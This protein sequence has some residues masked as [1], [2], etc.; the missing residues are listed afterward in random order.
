[1]FFYC[2]QTVVIAKAQIKNY[3][4][5]GSILTK[6]DSLQLLMPNIMVHNTR[7]NYLTQWSYLLDIVQ[8]T[9]Q[10]C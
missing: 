5:E 2:K 10:V 7:K 4:Q 1:M 9:N 8:Q 6:E 3:L